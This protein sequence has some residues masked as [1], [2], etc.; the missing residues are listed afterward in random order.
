MLKIINLSA[1]LIII[2]LK[3]IINNFKNIIKIILLKKNIDINL[4]LVL[5]KIILK[6]IY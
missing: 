4:L 2:F 5:F 3:N 6:K 1:F